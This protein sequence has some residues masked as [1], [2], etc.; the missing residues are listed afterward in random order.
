MLTKKDWKRYLDDKML[1]KRRKIGRRNSQVFKQWT[2]I[3]CRVYS[4]SFFGN[5]EEVVNR[6]HALI[7]LLLR[8]AVHD[9]VMNKVAADKMEPVT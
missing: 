9:V 3:M 2:K 1:N 8:H 5:D 6:T 7:G 4:V